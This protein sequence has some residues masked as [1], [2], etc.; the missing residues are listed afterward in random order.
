M[1][2]KLYERLKAWWGP[3][4]HE[5]MFFQWR[6]YAMPTW[7]RRMTGIVMLPI[8][9][10]I[11]LKESAQNLLVIPRASLVITSR[12]NLKCRDCA[13][14]IPFYKHAQDFEI[15]RL[16]RDVDDFLHN[17]DGIHEL[18]VMGGETF[19]YPELGRLVTHLKNRDKIGL[20]HLFTN[21]TIIPGPDILEVLRHKK[22]AVT[23]STFPVEVSG[24][25]NRCISALKEN[26]INTRVEKSMWDDVGG[27]NPCVETN[28]AALKYRY[29]NCSR[30]VCHTLM[31][32]EYH[33]CP[34]SAHGPHV[35]QFA[36]DARDSVT[37][38]NRHDPVAFKKELQVLLSKEYLAACAKCL[39]REGPS[40]SPGIQMSPAEKRAAGG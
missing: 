20:I 38:R 19:M 31:D 36:R 26:G 29:A 13:N 8:A 32:G 34:R 37:F 40:V 27:L 25:K 35:G 15:T 22:V 30:T 7:Q 12:C 33:L 5:K 2:P 21:G 24:N 11:R 3:W 23:V 18:R 39:G 16:I 4:Y 10:G 28:E 6:I 9:L 17:V 14:L 1:S